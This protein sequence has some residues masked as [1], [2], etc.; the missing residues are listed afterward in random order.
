VGGRHHAIWELK[1]WVNRTLGLPDR[2]A[3]LPDLHSDVVV[4]SSALTNGV[5]REVLALR[6]PDNLVSLLRSPAPPEDCKLNAAL[7]PGLVLQLLIQSATWWK[8]LAGN[9]MDLPAEVDLQTVH[10][11]LILRGETVRNAAFMAVASYFAF[12]ACQ[13][14]QGGHAVGKEWPQLDPGM[15]NRIQ[16]ILG[17]VD[18]MRPRDLAG[19]LYTLFAILFGAWAEISWTTPV[20]ADLVPTFAAQY[21]GT[22]ALHFLAEL[23][24]L[25][26]EGEQKALFRTVMAAS[27]AAYRRVGNPIRSSWV[28]PIEHSRLDLV[29]LSRRQPVAI[30]RH[31]A[32]QVARAFERAMTIVMQSFGFYVVT[33]DLGEEIS[34]L[35]CICEE[36][37]LILDC[38]TSARPY[39]LPTDDSRALRDYVARVRSDLR[40]LP[41]LSL[42][43]VVGPPPTAGLARRLKQLEL[44]AQLPVRYCSAE[45]LGRLRGMIPGAVAPSPFLRAAHES[46]SVIPDSFADVITAAWEKRQEAHSQFVKA[47]LGTGRH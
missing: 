12:A 45:I 26:G 17:N 3:C 35:I 47:L 8:A 11:G 41:A 38:K 7:D 24:P 43:L 1:T 22:T 31:G 16:E 30:K 5:I 25:L 37:S 29:G 20:P 32:P 21:I 33:A 34:D 18:K 14:I 19:V 2:R 36:Y 10:P 15:G 44:E 28:P 13:L 4:A 46:P 39:S 23:G 40:T 42:L 6:L 9:E 27:T